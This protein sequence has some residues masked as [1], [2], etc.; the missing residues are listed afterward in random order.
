MT[1]ALALVS[2]VFPWGFYGVNCRS[3]RQILVDGQRKSRVNWKRRESGCFGGKRGVMRRLPSS[4]LGRVVSVCVSLLLVSS[5]LGSAVQSAFALSDST[6]GQP[7]IPPSISTSDQEQASAA[8]SAAVDPTVVRELTA[9]RT[10]NSVTYQLSDGE[11]QTR[12][13][14]DAINYTA[15]DGSMRP[16]DTN[17]EPDIVDGDGVRTDASP[18]TTQFSSGMRSAP[19]TISTPSWSASVDLI[20]ANEPE[21][22]TF[23]S[24]AFYSNVTTATDLSYEAI[25]AGAKETLILRDSTA[26][27]T[28]RFRL[29]LA[30][31]E[32]RTGPLGDV[33]AYLPGSS[34]EVLSLGSV[35][36]WDS[37]GRTDT[38]GD[39]AFCP[40]ASATVEPVPGGAIVTYHVDPAWLADP[41][42][43]FPVLVDPTLTQM[44]GKDTFVKSAN[45]STNTAFGSLDYIRAGMADSTTGHNRGYVS[46]DL[47]SLTSATIS[48]A[49]ITLDCFS[50]YDPNNSANK[51]VYVRTAT[52]DWDDNTTWNTRPGMGSTILGNTAVTGT[53]FYSFN[54]GASTV[55]GWVNSP[56]TN[57][58]LNVYESEAGD[59][60]K[61]MNDFYSRE[62]SYG[63]A[64][65]L[66]VT[67][68]QNVPSA[69]TTGGASSAPMDWFRQADSNGDG[70]PD[71]RDD[72]PRRGRGSVT[73]TWTAAPGASGY[74][75]WWHDG[76]GWR[77]VGIASGSATTSW[78]SDGAG[79][80]PSD[81]WISQATTGGN[82]GCQAISPSPYS[83][84]TSFNAK[85][86]AG[87]ALGGT[88]IVVS[89][90]TNIYTHAWGGYPGSSHWVKVASGLKGSGTAGSF[91]ATVGA[92]D[93]P[94]CAQPISGLYLDGNLYYGATDGYDNTTLMGMPKSEPFSNTDTTGLGDGTL[95]LSL[96]QPLLNV[97]RGTPA[98]SSEGVL[99][100]SDGK[101]IY[102][103]AMSTG[104]GRGYDGWK[105]R[106]W[107]HTG[108]WV[109]D[110]IIP[111]PSYYTGGFLVDGK[112]VYFIE[113][114]NT[115][116]ARV[117][118]ASLVTGNVTG[119][120]TIDQ[121][122]S[123]VVG[124][125]YDAANN[126]LWLGGLGSTS[127]LNKVHQFLGPGL[128]LRDNPNALYKKLGPTGNLA[129]ST[130]Y[131]FKAVPY[132]AA[133]EATFANCATLTATLPNRSA[134]AL[135][136]PSHTGAALGH[137]LNKTITALL[138]QGAV[139]LDGT[140]LAVSSWGPPVEVS[141]SYS[142]TNTLGTM[143][144]P[145]WRFNFETSIATAV[146]GSPVVNYVD[147]SGETHSFV[148]T[149]GLY[150]SPAGYYG[151][152]TRDASNWIL[153]GKDGRSVARFDLATGRMLSVTDP[154]GN[155][156]TYNWG[157]AGLT[158]TA[159]N[160]QSIVVAIDAAGHVTDATY[161]TGD[162]TREVSYD[163]T[164]STATHYPGVTGQ[165]YTEHYAYAN[166][167]LQAVTID[168]PSDGTL[169]T[170]T[171]GYEAQ[172]PNRFT[173][174]D[175]PGY[176]VGSDLW[177]G[178]SYS[179]T[180]SAATVRDHGDV[181]G[182]SSEI[183]RSYAWN[184]T[185]TE[186]SESAPATSGATQSSPVTRFTYG[187]NNELIEADY[188][189]GAKDF[190]TVDASGNIL[191]EWDEQGHT[192]SYAYDQWSDPVRKVDPRGRQ[193]VW[194]YDAHGN[195]TT[196]AAQSTFETAVGYPS[197]Y[198]VTNR[199][200]NTSGTILSEDAHGGDAL[201]G[202]PD[203]YVTYDSFGLSGSWTSKTTHGVTLGVAPPHSKQPP[204]ADITIS[205]GIDAFGNV[206]WTQDPLGAT[207]SSVTY[208]PTTKLQ[209]VAT[210]DASGTTDNSSYDAY[211]RVA[212]TSATASDGSSAD[213][214]VTTH[215][216]LGHPT[217]TT[218]PTE[219]GIA[220]VLTAQY[221]ALGRKTAA[222]DSKAGSS[223]L[224]R[225]D[226]A[227]RL[228]QHWSAG[229]NPASNTTSDRTT[230][231]AYGRPLSEYSAGETSA[232]TATYLPNGLVAS[233]VDD[234]GQRHTYAYDENGNKTQEWVSDVVTLTATWNYDAN[235][236]CVKSTDFAGT[237]TWSTYDDLGNLTS[238][239]KSTGD[240]ATSYQTNAL[241]N[242]V[243]QQDP[244]GTAI[245][246]TY[247]ANGRLISTTQD[248]KT[249]TTDYD[250]TGA[251]TRQTSPSGTVEISYDALGRGVRS[252]F[253][254]HDG[255][256]W[257]DIRTSYDS[258]SRPLETSD[259]V[260][261]AKSD[262][263]YPANPGDPSAVDDTRPNGTTERVVNGPHGMEEYRS[264]S[265]AGADPDGS[266]GD[267]GVLRSVWE[268]DSANRETWVGYEWTYG[269]DKRPYVTGSVRASYDGKG[270]LATL[271]G[272]GWNG[273]QEGGTY[274]QGALYS[275]SASTGVVASTT[276]HYLFGATNETKS[277][278]YDGGGRLATWLDTAG[279]TASAT[280]DGKGYV[281]TV[282]R[283]VSGTNRT[284]TLSYGQPNGTGSSLALTSAKTVSGSQRYFSLDPTTG[285]RVAEALNATPG[286]PG[287][288]AVATYS[289]TPEGRLAAISRPDGSGSTYTYDPSGQRTMSVVV[290]GSVI[291]TTSWNYDGARLLS[292]SASD[293]TGASWTVEYM[294]ESGGAP[295]A[296]VYREGTSTIV[297]FGVTTN[298]HGDIVEL[299]QFKT[300][301]AFAL[302][303]YDAWG[304]GTTPLSSAV[305]SIAADLASRVA[306]RQ[307]L[308]Y[309]TYA[310]DNDS[311]LYYC[312]QRYY[313]QS[314][315]QFLS[316][317]PARAD[318]DLSAFM[319]CGDDPVNGSDPSGNDVWDDG[320]SEYAS[321][322]YH[323]NNPQ[324]VPPVMH[325]GI[326]GG[327]Y[328]GHVYDGA[329]N[330]GAREVVIIHYFSPAG[331]GGP[332]GRGATPEEARR[333]YWRKVH[334]ARAKARRIFLAWLN[335]MQV[336]QRF[337]IQY[338]AA[339]YGNQDV[340]AAMRGVLDS[341]T[342]YGAWP[343]LKMV[344]SLKVH[345]DWNMTVL[346]GEGAGGT[347]GL[348]D[349]VV[350]YGD[351]ATRHR[352]EAYAGPAFGLNTPVSFSV[353]GGTGSNKPG[354]YGQVSGGYGRYVAAGGVRWS[355]QYPVYGQAGLEWPSPTRM[356]GSITL[357]TPQWDDGH[358]RDAQ[359]NTWYDPAD[360]DVLQDR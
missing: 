138:D 123:Q 308:R 116:A 70:V 51:N 87:A 18:V 183:D 141:R 210:A 192:T 44:V 288:S 296:G 322:Y 107:D 128:D 260:T 250:G 10:E 243:L 298:E 135:E 228:V 110:L 355:G 126:A 131:A 284:T 143:G 329:G 261:G 11:L 134:S 227:G 264:G 173:E 13:S 240:G 339:F 353:M 124:G 237:T 271:D 177:T 118:R 321:T 279:N 297:P 28:Y 77:K 333:D 356:Q 334:A 220:R 17:L 307:V 211:G 172:S 242:V 326:Y 270:R 40:D 16:I 68:T 181:N 201:S 335:R 74:D 129:N 36:V 157:A 158:M 93:D 176:T 285:A 105:I 289:W 234:V 254:D 278:T 315:L 233:S 2:C 218:W 91:I 9:K 4:W 304:G 130:N 259:A 6:A 338:W 165:Q 139:R 191:F 152:L 245:Y 350:S 193:F 226:P 55:Q 43:V 342:R 80:Y 109:R 239:Q 127:G 263:T 229:S 122:S 327:N 203:I 215:D 22:L 102:D 345:T 290:N 208:Q 331:P 249:S 45:D 85:D 198:A 231:D 319:Y 202:A 291:T 311:G 145:G 246:N 20:G 178:V 168:S 151:T 337:R 57:Y 31:L 340:L 295:Y 170:W 101:D 75:I 113:W 97:W 72:F 76:A 248:G 303:R 214:S 273:P 39:P 163:A 204:L 59:Q 140:D 343:Q 153:T 347:V 306:S 149:Q 96:S 328:D 63:T 161:Q 247:D 169:G 34:T 236:K 64:P 313:D 293:S 241:G 15:S 136:D 209:P 53:G 197:G 346:F 354:V 283:K 309:A 47:S 144:P 156:A 3:D 146:P 255:T 336:D 359:P 65:Q 89:D 32:I 316:K 27:T 351:G 29:N 86:G 154:N 133:G 352:V 287:S 167:R 274:P 19:V 24:T 332:T 186:T 106:V 301:E 223:E 349:N 325:G 37:S 66:N 69:V 294:H 299:T 108:G 48:A 78:S 358:V 330:P 360:M 54:V 162:G 207:E 190:R 180:Q 272:S 253:S 132:N 56:T 189:S 98:G 119:R 199:T 115:D 267:L 94:T 224:F 188:P 125:A 310:W 12:I 344:S 148:A 213:R 171:F 281:K 60:D 317:D 155:Q 348:V 232:S 73:L 88:G 14:A 258:I 50:H 25:S 286:A 117:T 314:T 205:R 230:F 35:A 324:H 318:D 196:E 95:R 30:G 49:S 238:T 61:F 71:T 216:A 46:F 81:T 103:A 217:T 83:R 265:F 277:W 41:A 212:E 323:Y 90:G 225:F 320:S 219:S 179:A 312:S 244:D 357:L 195:A 58:G 269:R 235:G 194:D 256:P 275:Y 252:V 282:T 38:G 166:A 112:S 341:S 159:A 84:V 121:G 62:H 52:A 7:V 300:G 1:I 79:I 82:A 120:W 150:A 292:F 104:V 100:A 185:G 164:A 92:A 114:T 23:G 175:W 26:P 257:H 8:A 99:I 174:L 137:I 111:G 160:G 221:D 5:A 42:R 21:P 305:T 276:Y 33:A 184:I 200:Y 222:Y 206:V 182:S 280:Y 266:G 262:Y 67:Y 142:S 187:P 251:V 268:T 302:Y 147:E